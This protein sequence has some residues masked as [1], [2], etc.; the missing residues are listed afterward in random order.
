MGVIF[1]SII[2]L[3]V[4][5]LV[6][7][8][9]SKMNLG[10]TVKG[11]GAAIIAALVIAVVTGIVFWLLGLLSI[12]IGGGLLG[13]IVTVVIAAVILRFSD[14]F[15]PGMEVHGFKGAIIAAI[16]IGV[17]SW[18]ISYLLASPFGITI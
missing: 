2:A 4:A 5:A 11:Y 17:V 3:L 14:R 6:I 7:W 9:V 16:A 18:L 10:L 1:N 12:T 13:W 8:I 15:V